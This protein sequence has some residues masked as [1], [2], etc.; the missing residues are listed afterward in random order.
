MV[1]FQ[2]PVFCLFFTCLRVGV[3]VINSIDG[4]VLIDLPIFEDI[5]GSFTKMW[6]PEIEDLMPS[7]LV[8][9]EYITV[10][11]KGVLRGMH[12]QSPPFDHD[13]LVFCQSGAVL[14]VL[15]DL[16]RGSSFGAVD[17]F[18]LDCKNPKALFIP[19]G[20]AH[21]FLSLEDDSRMHYKTTTKHSPV[22]DNGVLWHSID[23]SWPETSPLISK[24]DSQFPPISDIEHIF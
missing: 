14:D 2:F 19:A 12:F 21:G 3:L 6:L 5:R 7:R 23:F 1:S 8:K 10:S 20:I 22:H 24:R 18:N 11:K 13:K 16:R 17:S 9:D 15:V 4:V